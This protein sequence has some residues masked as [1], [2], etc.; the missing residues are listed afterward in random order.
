MGRC[1]FVEMPSKLIYG[2]VW[3]WVYDSFE[4]AQMKCDRESSCTG[5]YQSTPTG[6]FEVRTGDRW[7]SAR[8]DA[9]SWAC[10]GFKG[11][12]G[13]IVTLATPAPTGSSAL[14]GD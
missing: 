4:D 11:N 7:G 8:S 10:Y 14:G 3:N 6:R 9:M 1:N 13:M 5:I 12:G 2:Y